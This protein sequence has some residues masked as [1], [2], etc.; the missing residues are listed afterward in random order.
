MIPRIRAMIAFVLMI[1]LLSCSAASSTEQVDNPWSQSTVGDWSEY[2]TVIG[3][4]VALTRLT[5][6]AKDE[7]NVT[8]ERRVT[9]EDF[10][11]TFTQHIPLDKPWTRSIL[12][13]PP[14]VTVKNVGDGTETL[15]IGGKEYKCLWVKIRAT[16]QNMDDTL[17][18]WRCNEVPVDGLVKAVGVTKNGEGSISEVLVGFGHVDL[19]AGAAK[20]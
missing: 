10:V 9:R 4:M 6:T 8:I 12:T 1:F 5:V 7:K 14:S 19:K 17:T 13:P 15:T 20:Q 18:I 3:P 16:T 2:K 11:K